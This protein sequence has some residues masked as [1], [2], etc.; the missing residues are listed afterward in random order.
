[1]SALVIVSH[2]K[3]GVDLALKHKLNGRVLDVIQQHHGTSSVYYFYRRAVEHREAMK[4]RVEAGELHPED[5]PDVNEE[6][7][8]YPGPLPNF[9]ES[10]IIS[11]ADA[12]ESA[13]RSLAKPSQS[14]IEHLVHDIIRGRILD[15]QLAHSDLTLTDLDRIETSFVKTLS[16]TMHHRVAYP[17]A[18]KETATDETEPGAGKSKNG[19][20]SHVGKARKTSR[21]ASGT[22]KP[23]KAPAKVATPGQLA[24]DAGDINVKPPEAQGRTEMG[25]AKPKN[26]ISTTDG[27]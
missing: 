3:D 25:D 15:G 16:S 11:L 27:H 14:K 2:V 9:R 6:T 22:K 7:F 10:A 12:V 26:R 13:S 4:L 1:M 24:P 19:R 21:T 5:L 23:A 18:E 8:R 17:N 20:E